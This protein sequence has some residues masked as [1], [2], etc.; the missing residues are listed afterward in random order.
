MSPTS[1]SCHSY[2][3]NRLRC[4]DLSVKSMCVQ[5][6]LTNY[7]LLRHAIW[8]WRKSIHHSQSR[9]WL[10]QI[11]CKLRMERSRTRCWIVFFAY[12]RRDNGYSTIN[13]T[14]RRTTTSY[15]ITK[16]SKNIFRIAIH[17]LHRIVSEDRITP[18]SFINSET[19]KASDVSNKYT[20]DYGPNKY[21]QN[22]CVFQGLL[23][24][25]QD[26]CNCIPRYIDDIEDHIQERFET[27]TVSKYSI[28]KA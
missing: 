21:R 16:Y 13:T 17:G 6:V 26:Y 8:T 3:A 19:F 23:K 15:F 14:H 10:Q 20:Y 27:N 28:K 7:I 12:N 22:S 25:I 5:K 24:G 9:S 2:T 1:Q 11:G 4:Y 18:R